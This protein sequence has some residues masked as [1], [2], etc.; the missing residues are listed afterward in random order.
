[1][2][3]KLALPSLIAAI[4]VGKVLTLMFVAFDS[5]ALLQVLP[6]VPLR[7]D[8]FFG[9]EAGPNKIVRTVSQ[10]RSVD[11]QRRPTDIRKKSDERRAPEQAS[12]V[13]PL[14][15]VLRLLASC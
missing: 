1:M 5:K 9:E 13:L 6:F 4:Y 10:G 14:I 11:F 8:T 7:C 3:L 2:E 12:G 15:H